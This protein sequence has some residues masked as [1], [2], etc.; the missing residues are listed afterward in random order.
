MARGLKRGRAEGV[1]GMGI[2]VIPLERGKVPG[3]R[4][5]VRRDRTVETDILE[6]ISVNVRLR[7]I[8]DLGLWVDGGVVHLRG[9]VKNESEQATLRRA[10]ALVRGVHAVWDLVERPDRLPLKT[11]DIGCGSH[12][13]AETA[14]GLDRSPHDPVEVVADLEEGLPFTDGSVDHI[15][16]VHVLE[17]VKN[18]IPLMNDIHRVLRHD[19]VLHVLVPYWRDAVAVA[20]PTHVRFFV[21]QSFR[22][23]CERKEGVRPYRP[24]MIS[25]NRDT[26]FADLMPDK[27]GMG[28][29]DD[30]MVRFFL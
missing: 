26:V 28:A 20:D 11:I 24:L 17:H 7:H 16:A 27:A 4:A 15:F 13:Q 29:G 14:V 2:R 12:K 8:K 10:V 30:D 23:F 5:E 25:H 21:P 9:F 6:A 22:I 18:L 19:G 1:S 3:E